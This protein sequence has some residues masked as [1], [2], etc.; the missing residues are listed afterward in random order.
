M[1][2][3]LLTSP[4]SLF[5][6]PFIISTQMAYLLAVDGG[7]TK[8]FFVLYNTEKE[9][10]ELAQFGTTSHEFLPGGYTELGSVL[11][12]ISSQVLSKHDLCPAD[13]KYSVWGLAGQ[14]TISQH[15]TIQG[16]IWKL[17]FGRFTLCNDSYL[18]IKAALPGGC[19]ICLING[20]G[21]N[22][23]GINEKGVTYQMGGQFEITGDFGGGLMLGKEAIKTTFMNLFRHRR[24][25]ILSK[26]IMEL[27][28]VE[29]RHD[30]MDRVTDWTDSG[31]MPIPYAAK[32]VFDAANLGDEEA[33]AMLKRMAN[34]YALSTRSLLYELPFAEEKVHIVLA[35]SLFTKDWSD[36]HIKTLEEKLKEYISEKQFELHKLTQPPVLGALAWA[37]EEAGESGPWE[38]AKAALA[39]FPR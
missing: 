20:T 8:T 5:P 25:T 18:G 10:A 21:P 26:M 36:I 6:F 33:V 24:E 32:S 12:D 2:Y 22:V 38:K 27:Y 14:D 28:G 39:N 31:K 4:F 37:L 15:K 34:E 16:I 29:S 35:G 1:P 7:G 9:T 30:F 23:V 3:S 13:I 11:N 17:G 19:G